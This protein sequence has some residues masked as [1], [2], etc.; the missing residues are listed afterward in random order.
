M[1]V[2]VRNYLAGSFLLQQQPSCWDAVVILDSGLRPSNFVA[3]HS[4]RHVFLV[5]DD[6][7]TPC[8][9]KRLAVLSD[10]QTAI[11]FAKSSKRLMVCCRAGQ[12]RS[13]AIATIIMA[14][15]SGVEAAISLLDPKRHVPNSR[16]ITLGTEL[17]QD[18]SL[19][20]AVE[21]WR[22]TYSHIRLSDYYEAIEKEYDELE[23]LG[24]S[25][26]ISQ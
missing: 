25:D 7:T 9:D 21:Q 6:V 1:E 13:A 12:S 26:K 15:H 10:I 11:E 3:D 18:S 14:Q 16:V 4:S 8:T 17:L 22:Q 23:K 24:A 20:E 2:L 5:F 19:A